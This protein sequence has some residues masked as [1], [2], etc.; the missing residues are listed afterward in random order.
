MLWSDK[1]LNGCGMAGPKMYVPKREGKGQISDS[2]VGPIDIIPLYRFGEGAAI[3]KCAISCWEVGW[4][5]DAHGPDSRQRVGP[6]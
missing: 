3:A 2:L 4:T 1:V 6:V 5:S